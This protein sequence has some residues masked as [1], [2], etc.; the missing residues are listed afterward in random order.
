MVLR[1]PNG[2]GK[3]TLL[4]LMA[5]LAQPFVGSLAWNGRALDEDFGGLVRYI[6]HLDAI[7]PGLT[8]RENLSFWASLFGIPRAGVDRALATFD[9]ARLADFP[10]RLFS[11][12]QRHRLALARLLLGDAP[13]WLLDEPANTLDDASLK[14]LTQAISDHRRRGGMVV[15]ASHGDALT[16][17]AAVMAL[18]AFRPTKETAE[19]S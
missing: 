3:T 7:K 9:L 17:D 15:I 11:A 13:L 16:A 10:A 1:G 2:S 14:A 19:T 12:G 5:G 18:D 4:R 6:G 8:A